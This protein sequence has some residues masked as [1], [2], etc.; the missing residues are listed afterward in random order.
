MIAFCGDRRRDGVAVHPPAHRLSAGRGPG[1]HHQPDHPAR[2]RHPATHPGRG[3]AG[4]PTLLNETE[5]DNVDFIFAVAGFTFAGVG[6]ECRHRLHPSEGLGASARARRTAPS[7][8][9]QRAFMRLLRRSATPRSSRSCRPRCRSWAMPPASTCQL[10]D[11]GNLGHAG[12]DAG[13]QPVAG[14]GGAGSPAGRCAPQQ[15]GR[16]AA[17]AYR[18]RPGQGQRAG[19]VA[20][21]HQL[22]PQRRLGLDLHQRLHRPRPRQ[23]R[24]YAGRRAL[25]HDAGRSEP[26]V[27]AQQHRHHGA[28]LVLRHLAL[29]HRARRR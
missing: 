16:H 24:L 9:A 25:S 22:H 14:H 15:P 13:P 18:Y 27:C 7:A 12:A 1:L 3:A 23:A 17:A 2:R 19:R 6:P 20:G 4:R 26:L 8:I 5:K 10:E 21:R 29:D 28:L 11:R